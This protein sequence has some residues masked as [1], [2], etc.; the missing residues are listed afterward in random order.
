MSPAD[1]IHKEVGGIQIASLQTV[2]AKRADIPPLLEKLARVCGGAVCGP[3]MTIFHYG[4]V[5]DGILVEVAYPVDRTVETSEVHTRLLEKRKAWTL[6]H[7]GAPETNR[8]ATQGI[9]QYL[10]SHAGTIGGGTREIYLQVDP[11]LPENCVTE[12]QVMDHEWTERLSTGIVEV[13][14]EEACQHV[15]Q[16]IETI[17]VD[18]SAD[19]YRSW[20]H[21]A[22]ARIDALT[23]DPVEKYR[24]VSCA[25]HVFPQYR[26]DHLKIIYE[27]RYEIDDVLVEMYTDP[28][29]YE[30]PVR[31]G[32]QLFMRK[33]PYDVEAYEKATSPGERRQ[34]Y[35]HCAIVRPYLG[36]MPTGIS[37]TF[38]WC[39]SGWYR[40]LW[41]GILGKPI[42]VDH[43]E[44]LITGGDCCRLV[45][46]LPVEAQGECHPPERRIE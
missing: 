17:A 34:A 8:L 14:G 44:T 42:Q 26:I 30:D 39:G 41:E 24:I 46:T 5:K 43:V 9:F 16:G 20:I 19:N 22:M 31:N 36:D 21:G 6:N 37:P 38:C 4:S 28:A 27:K 25:A 23:N 33:I 35:C 15:M 7:H 1:V 2:I 3:A 11:L 18:S 13:L 40:R 45:I 29:W 32:N 12:I 10:E